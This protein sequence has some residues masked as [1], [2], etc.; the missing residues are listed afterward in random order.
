MFIIVV[1]RILPRY[2]QKFQ[3]I[4]WVSASLL[5]ASTIVSR[6]SQ[7]SSKLLLYYCRRC[8]LYLS[9]YNQDRQ[10]QW[11]EF[12]YGIM[13]LLIFSKAHEKF[14]KNRLVNSLFC[15]LFSARITVFY[16]RKCSGRW[17]FLSQCLPS[18]GKNQSCL[19]DHHQQILITT[20]WCIWPILLIHCL[21]TIDWFKWWWW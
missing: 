18:E 5:L 2:V 7:W 19:Q 12:R 17:T 10:T 13:C 20:D 14:R 15:R 21:K 4:I 3:Y 6:K 9:Q 16:F 1:D 8:W 11:Q